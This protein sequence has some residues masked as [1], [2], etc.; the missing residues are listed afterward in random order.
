[1]EITTSEGSKEILGGVC[2]FPSKFQSSAIAWPFLVG[3]FNSW[4]SFLYKLKY[5][6]RAIAILALWE[7]CF[8]NHRTLAPILAL[9][10]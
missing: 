4:N 10:P 1:M 9:H 8:I 7:E 3:L 2:G 5:L 6:L